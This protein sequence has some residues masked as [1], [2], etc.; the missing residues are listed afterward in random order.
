MEI[1][2]TLS[3]ISVLGIALLL[4]RSF[5]PAYTSEKGKNLATKQDIEAITHKIESVRSFYANGLKQL[6]HRHERL[7]EELRSKQQLRMAAAEKRLEAHQRGYALWRK[8]R[9]NLYSNEI[10]S[11]VL[12]CQ[13]WW[14][15]SCLYLTPEAR[16]AFRLAYS[17]AGDHR[18][19]LARGSGVS[20]AD[21]RENYQMIMKAGDAIVSDV[22]LPTLG[23]R[24]AEDVMDKDGLITQ[25][26]SNPQ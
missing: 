21:V 23:E 22:G 7:L 2:L 3:I 12:E 4:W 13:E 20:G 14:I 16:E 17:F 9:S 26:Q 1:V 15:N 6:D 24:E 8:L 10:H 19:L 25:P 5:L 18:S 11:V